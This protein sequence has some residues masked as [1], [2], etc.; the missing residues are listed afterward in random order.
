[1]SNPRIF[2]KLP[3]NAICAEIG[4]WLGWTTE[5]LIQTCQPKKLHLIDPYVLYKNDPPRLKK[6]KTQQGMDQIFLQVSKK[7]VNKDV[8]FH[9]GRSQVVVCGFLDNYFD[10]IYIDGDHSYQAVK[11]DLTLYYH[12]VKTGGL[13]T[14]DD[15]EW[16]PG[17]PVKK[18]VHEF[19]KDFNVELIE[20]DQDG[21]YI[22]KK[23]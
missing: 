20:V 9:R 11:Q 1:M 7:L 2:K 19:I 16:G 10:W 18:A 22:I 4:V 13:I 5:R 21:Q 3:K 8:I 6:A 23:K 14:G 15:Y 12:K 17:K